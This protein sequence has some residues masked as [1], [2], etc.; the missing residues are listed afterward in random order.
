MK[1]LNYNAFLSEFNYSFN[2]AN[3]RQ[4]LAANHYEFNWFF[5]AREDS[6]FGV[7]QNFHGE[8]ASVRISKSGEVSCAGENSQLVDRSMAFFHLL[9]NDE[10]PHP[11]EIKV[12]VDAVQKV[13][14]SFLGKSVIKFTGVIL[15]VDAD[16]SKGLNRLFHIE[17]ERVETDFE[18]IDEYLYERFISTNTSPYPALILSEE[19]YG[20]YYDF[21]EN[22]MGAR[23]HW[24]QTQLGNCF[25]RFSDDT[26]ISLNDIFF[27]PYATLVGDKF[28][29]LLDFDNDLIE[30]SPYEFTGVYG[31]RYENMFLKNI[32]QRSLDTGVKV[33]FVQGLLFDKVS[34]WL[35]IK[36]FENLGKSAW[37]LVQGD[38]EL[39]LE[40]SPFD[41]FNDCVF[42]G[43]SS[44]YHMPSKTL[45][46]STHKDELNFWRTKGLRGD[47]RL[48]FP[49]N[50]DWGFAHYWFDLFNTKYGHNLEINT[51]WVHTEDLTLNIELADKN[52]NVVEFSLSYEDQRF[53]LHLNEPRFL[54]FALESGLGDYFYEANGDLAPRSKGRKRQNVLKL[55]RHAGFF[56]LLFHEAVR[57]K[58]EG[59][60]DTKL[61]RSIR[62]L[63]AA[64]I[65]KTTKDADL[66]WKDEFGPKA[67]KIINEFLSSFNNE[68]ESFYTFQ[69][70]GHLY[71]TNITPVLSR[72]F[73]YLSD[74]FKNGLD[75]RV[76]T[77]QRF[78]EFK[79]SREKTGFY[80][81]NALEGILLTTVPAGLKVYLNGKALDSLNAEDIESIFKINETGEAIDWFELHPEVFLKGKRV[82]KSEDIVFH[83][84]GCIEHKGQYYLIPQ[85]TLPK[86]KWLDYFWKKL[87]SAGAKKSNSWD[88]KIE[89]IPKSQTLELLAMHE[90][91][92]P[93]QGGE[94][95]EKIL[96]EYQ[97]LKNRDKV[98]FE[99]DRDDYSVPLKEFQKSGTQW[100]IDLYRL[101]LGGILADDM[102]LG[103]TIQS[104]GALEWLRVNNEMGHCLVVVPTSLTYNWVSE[105]EKFAP[106]IVVFNYS[107]QTRDKH[108]KFLAKNKN[109]LTVITYGL[110][111]RNCKNL[112]N[113][114]TWNITLFDEAQNLKNI[115]ATRT[116][117]ARKFPCNVKFCLTGTPMENHYGEFY[118][119]VDI[120]VPG[121]LGS[122]SEF[123]KAFN[124]KASKGVNFKNME[125]DLEYL[126]LKTAPLVM[127]RTK[128]KIL[129]ELPDK[130]ETSIKLDFE[131]KQEKIYRDIAIAYNEKI[132]EVVYL[133][134]DNKSQ[135]E[136]LSAI[137]RLRQACSYPQALPEVKYDKEPPK[138]KA[139]FGQLS[140][141][142]EEGHK[143]LVFTNFKTTLL[144]IEQG[145]EEQGQKVFII[146]GATPKKKREKILKEYEEYEGAAV[147]GMTL[148]TGGVGLNLTC[149]NYV[150][151]VEPWW[152][153]A[154]ESQA[155]DRAHRM[156]QKNKV[157]VYRYIMRES[158][159]EKIE[160]LK[161]RKT[162][163]IEGLF[164][165]EAFN[166][167]KAAFAKTG[168]SYEDFEYLVGG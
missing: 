61:K 126:K 84:K 38:R 64:A 158:I 166:I 48:K 90:A 16:D 114:A 47:L 83:G 118:S 78:K 58:R 57:A 54:F 23:A 144:A 136:I 2:K 12:D 3:F 138:L 32:L 17:A 42:I 165:E 132:K 71:D 81:E 117:Y 148:K 88:A 19:T 75:E 131:A 70:G 154:A 105:V 4:W 26:I 151:H 20:L 133:K 155:T 107:S 10:L 73:S 29:E 56:H 79:S 24:N 55:L 45:F 60:A 76:L 161:Q 150:F 6:I 159:E 80:M 97:K 123:M 67:T 59:L 103:K 145:L 25:F 14:S 142:S 168:L 74:F 122:Y 111:N 13:V 119:L 109:S 95:W 66:V 104:I 125:Q 163:A 164:S 98:S 91:G 1:T 102:G 153:P 77:K 152:N 7:F 43:N 141:I 134:G 128:E 15:D 87:T 85:T 69:V 8:V 116:G 46:R 11:W 93:V 140:Q 96:S 36:S 27:H 63:A 50:Y 62:E 5:H 94:R 137:L 52:E 162:L 121:A 40:V 41:D 156:G 160:T 106:N 44:Y 147:L 21:F 72:I 22:K 127:R 31:D 37:K 124:F 68:K 129:K 108:E 49:E 35:E 120:A 110:F 18:V 143:S 146:T 101:G 28:F 99:F 82:N 9:L 51:Q 130:T 89:Q 115:T 30:L 100:M 53:P 167:K 113:D 86:V 157:Q 139:L 149:A 39:Y 65:L 112:E 135:L 92:I 34:Y 33:Y